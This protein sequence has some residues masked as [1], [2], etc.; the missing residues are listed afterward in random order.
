MQVKGESEKD[1]QEKGE[2]SS[3]LMSAAVISFSDQSR[4]SVFTLVSAH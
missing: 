3:C 2:K 4:T 1:A